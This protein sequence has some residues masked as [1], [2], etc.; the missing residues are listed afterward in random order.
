[1]GYISDLYITFAPHSSPMSFVTVYVWIREHKTLC[2]TRL[3][4]R[5][6]DTLRGL[7]RLQVSSDRR[8]HP[9]WKGYGDAMRNLCKIE[10]A[11]EGGGIRSERMTRRCLI[12][13]KTNQPVIMWRFPDSPFSPP[14]ALLPGT[15]YHRP[16]L[17]PPAI[18]LLHLPGPVDLPHRALLAHHRPPHTIVL[19]GLAP[20][21]PHLHSNCH[22]RPLMVI[23]DLFRFR[24]LKIIC[25]GSGPNGCWFDVYSA[26]GSRGLRGVG[27]TT[28]CGGC[29]RLKPPPP[30]P[31]PIIQTFLQNFFTKDFFIVCGPHCVGRDMFGINNQHTGLL[32]LPT[33]YSLPQKNIPMHPPKTIPIPLQISSLFKAPPLNDPMHEVI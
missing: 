24:S 28:S 9:V 3:R 21:N 6:R 26:A 20:L 2:K 15:R 30:F 18:P 33:Q 31:L 4:K 13:P 19:W 8:S 27:P 10:T 32:Q 5:L 29:R 25:P 11:F 7:R 17:H 22:E 1:M 23:P 16:P 14:R 12:E